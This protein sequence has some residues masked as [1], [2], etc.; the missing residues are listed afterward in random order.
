MSTRSEWLI[1][2]VLAA[3]S[4]VL[5]WP[6]SAAGQWLATEWPLPTWFRG[7]DWSTILIGAGFALLVLLPM[8][9]VT[10]ARWGRALGLMVLSILIYSLTTRLVI[11]GF[12][13]DDMD[14]TWSLILASGLGALLVALSMSLLGGRH[15]R[16]PGWL[17][18]TVAGL[19]VG[20]PFAWAIVQ[21]SDA[22]AVGAHLLWQVVIFC[23]LLWTDRLRAR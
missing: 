19:L 4:G 18:P 7:V 2:L 20:G 21:D 14:T 9:R 8:M 16:A 10:Q 3:L 13:I 11:H 17:I 23:S 15:W 22:L 12:W 6:L 5:T 1:G